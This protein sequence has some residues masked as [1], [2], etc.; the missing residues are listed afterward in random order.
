MIKNIS[1]YLQRVYLHVSCLVC[2]IFCNKN[3]KKFIIF[4]S[5]NGRMFSDNSKYLFKW[6][7]KHRAD[8]NPIWVTRNQDVYE[9]LK[10]EGYPVALASSYKICCLLHQA[11]LAVFTHSLFDFTITPKIIPKDLRLVALRHGKSVKRVRYARKGHKITSKEQRFRD[12]E[13]SLIKFAISTSDFISNIQDEC[14]QLGRDKHIVTGYPRNDI[15]YSDKE[16][17]GQWAQFLANK[18]YKRVILYAPSWR[19]GREPTRLFP[20]VDFRHDKLFGLLEE[21]EII[22]LIRLHPNDFNNKNEM[23][24]FAKEL[25]GLSNNIRIACNKI[26]PDVNEM[27]PFVDVLIS[28]YSAIYHDFLLLDR[29][30]MFIPYDYADFER[31]NGFLYD[32]FENLPGPAIS[33][34]EDFIGHIILLMEGVDSYAEKR[35]RLADQVHA[36]KDGK[37]C[38]RVAHLIDSVLNNQ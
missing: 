20:F 22:L 9:Q 16:F 19:H 24:L 15:F 8:E 26:F 2:G 35:R 3:S 13:S 34:F 10:L 21:N 37:S 12:K 30:L 32:Y 4:A 38:E 28:D 29:P 33:S 31:E 14:L 18:M 17:K 25:T 36:Y 23:H 27:L 7:V 5:S 6:F 1:S 11:K